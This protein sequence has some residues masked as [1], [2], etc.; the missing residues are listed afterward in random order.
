MQDSRLALE[1]DARGRSAAPLAKDGDK[2]GK[3]AGRGLLG[4]AEQ[5]P[6]KA[7]SELDTTGERN[8]L[9]PAYDVNQEFRAQI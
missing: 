9:C 4:A 3:D 2:P 6:G 5:A 7:V 1:L 8:K